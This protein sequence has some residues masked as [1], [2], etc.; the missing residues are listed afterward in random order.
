MGDRLS[1]N[2]ASIPR[3]TKKTAKLTF[4]NFFEPSSCAAA[5]L[6]PNART[7]AASFSMVVAVLTL[8]LVLAL[9]SLSSSSPPPPALSTSSSIAK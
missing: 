6:G 3:N 4:I 5:A 8:V 2:T 7:P 9:S 1:P